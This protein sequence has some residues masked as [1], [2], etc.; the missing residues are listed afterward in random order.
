MIENPYISP[1]TELVTEESEKVSHRFYVVSSKKFYTLFFAT[2]GSYQV[3]WFYKN[4]K[5][6]RIHTRARVLPLMRGIFSIFFTH[7]LFKEVGDRIDLSGRLFDWQPKTLATMIVLLN[8]VSGIVDRFSGKSIGSPYTDLL[9]VAL[10]VPIGMLL[11]KAQLAIN[12]SCDDPEGRTNDSFSIANYCW[13]AV[14]AV[15]W[16]LVF[17]GAFYTE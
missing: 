9:S 11:H 6:F 7:S 8:I 15:L 16:V 14:G 13:L 5:Q 17:I 2:L 4:W 3:Y 10:N 12:F 1:S